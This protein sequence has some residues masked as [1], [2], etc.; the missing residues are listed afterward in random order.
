MV[1]EHLTHDLMGLVDS[2]P[3][4]DV[5]QLKCILKQMLEGIEHMHS[6]GYY[7]RDL[8]SSNVLVSCDG[9]VKLCDLGLAK[10][11]DPAKP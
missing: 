1:F 3:K 10:F 11:V 8:K 7:H 9:E 2:E 5:S 4:W 6:L